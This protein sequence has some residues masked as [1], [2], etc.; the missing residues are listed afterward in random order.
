MHSWSF[1]HYLPIFSKME[2]INDNQFSKLYISM[3]KYKNMEKNT[4]IGVGGAP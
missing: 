4:I 3:N 1:S 2:R